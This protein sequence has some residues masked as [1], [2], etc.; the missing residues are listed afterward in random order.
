MA[1][2]GLGVALHA[3]NA[4][5]DRPVF[6]FEVILVHIESTRLARAT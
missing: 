5:R 2:V 3:F 6:E 1:Q 4:S